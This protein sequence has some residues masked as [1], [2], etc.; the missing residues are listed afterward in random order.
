MRRSPTVGGNEEG[1]A[2]SEAVSLLQQLVQAE[3]DDAG[4]EQLNDDEDGVR[5]S[6]VSD[7]TVHARCHVGNSLTDGDEDA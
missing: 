5:S 1:D 7:V 2:G 4:E 3:N 6:Q